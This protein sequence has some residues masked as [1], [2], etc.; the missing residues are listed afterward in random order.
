MTDE[1]KPGF[2]DEGMWW[3]GA[4]EELDAWKKYKQRKALAF[5]ERGYSVSW[6][7]DGD[8]W[9]TIY[10]P[11]R[12]HARAPELSAEVKVY[13]R[14]SEHGIYGGMVSKL[15]ILERRT[16]PLKQV[17]SPGDEDVRTLYNYDRGLDFDRLNG[18]PAAMRL[19]YAVLDELN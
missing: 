16:D 14:P 17:S 10:L 6:Y 3:I 5:V 11:E 19:F 7:P 18:H 1:Q 9:M 12:L 4:R 15:A 2:Y 8:N 13:G